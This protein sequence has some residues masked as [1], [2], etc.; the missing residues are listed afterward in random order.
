VE[1]QIR[2]IQEVH[3]TKQHL[4]QV[5]AVL[6]HTSEPVVTEVWWLPAAVAP[7]FVTQEIYTLRTP[8]QLDTWLEQTDGRVKGFTWISFGPVDEAFIQNTTS[9]P[10]KLTATRRLAFLT[11]SHFEIL[12]D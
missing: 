5:A 1:F 7:R 2:G 4:S 11:Y 8:N 10:V 6:T 12:P 3:L 9:P